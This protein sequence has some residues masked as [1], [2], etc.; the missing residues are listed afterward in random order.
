[1]RSN[2]W[3]SNTTSQWLGCHTAPAAAPQSREQLEP[4]LG[5]TPK[6]EGLNSKKEW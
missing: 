5:N 3:N 4:S 6:E 1:M 2:T